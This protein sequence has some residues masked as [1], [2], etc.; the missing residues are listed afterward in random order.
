MI[1]AIGDI[2]GHTDKLARAHDLIEA[3]RAAHGAP[4]WPVVHLGDY[5][6]RGP[7]SA[8]TVQFLIDGIAA[9]RPW[10]AIKGNHDRLLTGFLNDPDW[11]DPHL[12]GRLDWFDPRLGGAATLASYGVPDAGDRDRNEVHREAVDAV[13]NAHRVFLEERP[14]Y[15]QT[16]HLVFVHAGIRPGVPMVQQI[17]QEVIWIRNGF[18]DDDTDHGRLVVHGHTALKRPEHAGNRV[19]LDGGTGYGRPLIPA[20]FDEDGVWL[21][22][23]VGRVELLP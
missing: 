15:H 9:G 1:Y 5:N 8:G 17:E 7:D 19:N 22:T 12:A 2:H 4:D 10:I 6:D 20:V 16:E 11:E 18:L 21:L 3:D 14:L 23:D 13:P